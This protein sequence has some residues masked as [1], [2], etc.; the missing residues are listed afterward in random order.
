MGR[1]GLPAWTTREALAISGRRGFFI[2]LDSFL[3]YFY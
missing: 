3:S 2:R 1:I